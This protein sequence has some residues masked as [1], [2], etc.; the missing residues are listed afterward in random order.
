M[1]R[2]VK[3]RIRPTRNQEVMMEKTFGC[4][5]FLYNRMLNDRMTGEYMG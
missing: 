1:N 2:A 3:C 5:R 4:C